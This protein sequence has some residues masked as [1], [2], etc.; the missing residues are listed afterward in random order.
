MNYKVCAM[1]GLLV[2]APAMADVIN[3]NGLSYE[4]VSWSSLST[5]SGSATGMAGS[6]G[7]TFNTMELSSDS[8]VSSS[9]DAGSMQSISFRG[10]LEGLSS[11]TFDRSV[12]SIMIFVGN[13]GDVTP[14]TLFGASV[15][16]FDDSLDVSVA[17]SDYEQGFGIHEGNILTNSIGPIIQTGG[18]IVAS[19]SN[20]TSLLWDQSTNGGSDQMLISFAIATIPAPSTA[21]VLM[22]PGLLAGRR[23][24]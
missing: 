13:P 5:E 8:V 3:H 7:I 9:F 12:A 11:L 14:Q 19:G 1:A 15:W 2:S 20:L 24:R 21:L 23:R 22:V 6:V 10:G 16:D 4:T 17:A 18:M